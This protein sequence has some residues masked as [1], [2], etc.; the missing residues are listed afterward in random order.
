MRVDAAS[1][2]PDTRSRHIGPEPVAPSEVTARQ[3]LPLQP[4]PMWF[5]VSY[6]EWAWEDDNDGGGRFVP[7]LKQAR[8]VLGANGV[9]LKPDGRTLDLTRMSV[10]IAAN[11]GI[12]IDPADQR[13]G[14]FR[15]YLGAVSCENGKRY[16]YRWA[17]VLLSRNGRTARVV[18]NR[19]EHDAFRRHLVTAGVIGRMPPE[20]LDEEIAKRHSRVQVMQTQMGRGHL[21][22]EALH[23]ATARVDR[24]IATM[25]RTFE[26]MKDEGMVEGY[27]PAT[28]G[29]IDAGIV[30][31]SI[32][33]AAVD[34]DDMPAV[35]TADQIAP[36]RQAQPRKQAPGE[37]A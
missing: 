13:L 10:G 2:A 19:D 37:A 8:C 34:V 24:E 4:G 5:L 9:G 15:N 36:K 1:T 21:A 14:R 20:I 22:P 30:E 27:G 7:E 32:A 29:P 12:L 23:A 17:R 28:V 25:R 26:G 35:A 18:L 16:I 6:G 33:P 11:R 3:S 31:E